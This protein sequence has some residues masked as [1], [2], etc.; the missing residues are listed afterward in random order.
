MSTASSFFVYFSGST[1]LAD[2]SRALAGSLNVVETGELLHVRWRDRLEP[3]F[4]VR[5]SA[6]DAVVRAAVELGARHGIDEFNN[7]DQRFEVAIDD[8]PAALDEA[9]TLIEVQLTLQDLTNGYLVLS[10]NGSVQAPGD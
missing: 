7:L 8:L 4:T 5:F 3:E 10:W 6:G 9:N 2:A 1:T